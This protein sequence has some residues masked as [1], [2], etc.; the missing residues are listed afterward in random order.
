MKVYIFAYSVWKHEAGPYSQKRDE[1]TDAGAIV[2]PPDK[3]FT[4]AA[5]AIH[6]RYPS[7]QG[8]YISITTPR[9][10]PDQVIEHLTSE[11]VE[12]MSAL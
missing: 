9:E 3:A 10:L 8:Y 6:D 11:I 7:E 12:G 2:A 4:L 1:F 5:Q